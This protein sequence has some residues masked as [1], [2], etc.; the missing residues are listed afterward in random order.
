MTTQTLEARNTIRELARRVAEL[1]HSDE[2]AR[3][4]RLWQDV[5]SLRRPERPPVICH[6]GCWEELLPRAG[7]VSQDP[8]HADVEYSLRQMLTKHEIGDDTV[9]EPWWEVP[10]AM[11]LEGEHWWGLPV[12]YTHS[13]VAGGAWRYVHPIREEADLD[14]IVPPRF[15]HNA[16]QTGENLSR[17]HELLGDLLPV[18]VTCAVPGPGAC[19]HGWATQLCGVQPLLMHI[20]VSIPEVEFPSLQLGDATLWGPAAPDTY[21]GF[22]SRSG[23][24]APGKT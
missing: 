22:N 21:H 20:M 17:M 11:E 18:R 16:A 8:F 14:R 3:R 6:P 13:G 15:R 12:G 1:A 9:I 19:L 4:R 2:Y 10:A 7:L 24:P 23:I 5:N